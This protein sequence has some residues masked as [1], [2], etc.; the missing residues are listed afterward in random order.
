M[1]NEQPTFEKCGYHHSKTA[2]CIPPPFE[3]GGILRFSADE[4]DKEQLR[5][6]IESVE[7]NKHLLSPE[8]LIENW[9]VAADILAVIRAVIRVKGAT[10]EDI[11][12]MATSL[13]G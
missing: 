12:K 5:M 11:K 9:I 8:D 1:I 10:E 4:P 2:S 3:N 7:W 13:K 6:E